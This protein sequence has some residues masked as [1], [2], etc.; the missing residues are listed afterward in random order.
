MGNLRVGVV[1][2]QPLYRDMI[3][4]LLT[5][6]PGVAVAMTAGG[7]AEARAAFEP[8]A[9]DVAVLDVHLADG[10]GLALGVS[11][12]RRDPD[13]GILLL[14]SHDVMELLL[15]LPA[16]VRDGW[17]YLSK[18]STTSAEVLM[19][20]LESTAAGRTVV[21]PALAAGAYRREGSSLAQL[22]D[23]QYEVLQLVASGLSNAGIARELGLSER[24]VENHINAVYAAL[25]LPRD[26]NQ[27]VSAVLRF[28]EETARLDG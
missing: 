27:R 13:L 25:D 16:D 20:A 22:S 18:N 28:I 12:R 10:N 2:D 3:V 23:R 6:Q 7:A 5:A 1:E 14:S 26:R 17:S 19:R 9:L 8:G 4:A 24:S 15:D 21:D 11:L